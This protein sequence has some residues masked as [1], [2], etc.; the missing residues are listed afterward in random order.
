MK[1]TF[2]CQKKKNTFFLPETKQ[3][4]CQNWI[5][6]Q[7]HCFV[8]W[9]YVCNGLRGDCRRMSHQICDQSDARPRKKGTSPLQWV[10]FIS[11]W[12]IGAIIVGWIIPCLRNGSWSNPDFSVCHCSREKNIATCQYCFCM[13]LLWWQWNQRFDWF[14]AES[15]FPIKWFR[16][17][18]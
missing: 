16:A 18:Y 8:F 12:E 17:W 3:N 10:S 14:S 7:S 11:H 6:W 15:F 5:V 1:W 13:E 4:V 2:L 9:L